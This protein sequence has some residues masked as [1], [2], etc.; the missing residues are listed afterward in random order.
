M[1]ADRLAADI[2]A[3]L[4]QLLGDRWTKFKA[5]ERQLLARVADDFAALGVELAT[6]Q[7]TPAQAQRE[8]V[9]LLAQL[10]NL[11]SAGEAAGQALVSDLLMTAVKLALKGLLA[12]LLA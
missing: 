3:A 5:S 11:K 9:Q 12:P 7:L 2:L 4:R 10:A 6:G 1:N 8:K